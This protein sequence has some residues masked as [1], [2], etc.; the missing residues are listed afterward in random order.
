MKRWIG[1]FIVV[2]M[3]CKQP[4]SVPL[5]TLGR[6]IKDFRFAPVS[7]RLSNL[8]TLCIISES[9]IHH[10]GMCVRVRAHTQLNC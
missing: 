8:G 7:D 10:D 9:K 4:E 2:C 3:C 1:D 5:D 6:E